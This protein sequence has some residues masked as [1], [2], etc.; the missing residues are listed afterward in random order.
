MS[1]N[2]Y[3]SVINRLLDK[4]V[5]IETKSKDKR[6]EFVKG[7]IVD[8]DSTGFWFEPEDPLIPKALI[9]W[10]AFVKILDLEPNL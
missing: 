3:I 1:P 8:S 6:Y 10:D 5:E 4:R 7:K 9:N 2:C